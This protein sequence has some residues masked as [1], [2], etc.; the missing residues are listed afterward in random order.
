[1]FNWLISRR[2][3]FR[4][5]CVNRPVANLR[6]GP[7]VAVSLALCFSRGERAVPHGF[8]PEPALG[9]SRPSKAPRRR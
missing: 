3:T 4:N 2:L 6:D 8:G 1:M 7:E 5:S 9:S